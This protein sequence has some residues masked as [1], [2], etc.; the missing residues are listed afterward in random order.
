MTK[1]LNIIDQKKRLS[2]SKLWEIQR[3]YYEK[4]G[5]NAWRK[6]AVPHVITS[7]MFIANQYVRLVYA[8]LRDWQDEIDTDYPI[9]L[10][11][12]G[13]GSGRFSYHFMRRWLDRVEEFGDFDISF[14]FVLT[15]FTESNLKFWKSHPLMKE[16]VEQGIAEYALF[17]ATQD[18]RIHLLNSG[19]ILDVESL[20]NPIIVIANYLFDSIPVDIFYVENN[21]L[22]ESLAIL[23]S[24]LSPD[25][26]LITELLDSI[27]LRYENQL[28]DADYYEDETCNQIL[29]HYR[30]SFVNTYFRF[31]V[32]TFDCIRNLQALSQNRMMLIVADKGFTSLEA[33]DNLEPPQIAVHGSM[34]MM[35]N[36]DA[37]KQF[38]T[39]QD[40][41]WH[42]TPFQ[43]NDIS[44]QLGLFGNPN[45][46][47]HETA[48]TYY[49]TVA[50][51][52]ADDYHAI[53]TALHANYDKLPLNQLLSILRMGRWDAVL[54]EECFPH[55]MS[56]VQETTDELR[57]D[58]RL[59]L[60]NVWDNYYFIGEDRDVPFMIGVILHN[61]GAFQEAIILFN[62]SIQMHGMDPSTLYNMGMSYLYLGDTQK[63]LEYIG[64]A[65]DSGQFPKAVETR[66]KI[67]TKLN[68]AQ[69]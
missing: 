31:P 57:R 37:L 4:V 12:L 54:F 52:S 49:D 2:Q 42:S 28:I 50:S 24:G 32:T 23:E 56:K 1:N 21:Q 10:I 38:F 22:Y 15:D 30:Q 29:E 36:F 43:P 45:S 39:L 5:V 67:L 16:M 53:T 13:T 26:D 51:F 27:S 69:E 65:A 6:R 25:Y 66:E 62:Y 8:Y 3:Q 64:Q 9:Y 46:E 41:Q 68:E 48:M 55:I 19:E 17:D 47:Y 63:A 44:I 58:M 40:G 60:R 14:K 7:N 59:V 20:V 61:I 34:S 18:K 35:V 33:M 11:E